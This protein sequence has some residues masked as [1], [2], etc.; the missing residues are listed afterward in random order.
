MFDYVIGAKV[1]GIEYTVQLS[2]APV[3]IIEG[4]EYLSSALDPTPK[5]LRYQHHIGLVSGVA[6]DHANVFPTE[7]DYIHQFDRFAEQT[8]PGGSLY[9]SKQDQL[10]DTICSKD[11]TGITHFGY[12]PHPVKVQDGKV[13]LINE[14]AAYPIKVFGQHNYLNISGAKQI[15]KCIGIT[16]DQFY[17][18]ISSFEGAS[19][20]LEKIFE[21]QSYTV[22]KDFAHA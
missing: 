8:P 21:D 1:K 20:R 7:E 9:F 2:D 3:I 5:F 4:D 13:Y 10:A 17:E 12:E 15:S 18:A 19:G 6:W 11:R 14:G 22:Y 16:D